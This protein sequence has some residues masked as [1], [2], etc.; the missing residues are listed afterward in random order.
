M[1]LRPDSRKRS[2]RKVAA[3][4]AKRGHKTS[5]GKPFSAMT[6]KNMVEAT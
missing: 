5:A 1:L 3:E 6:V 4:L 2:L